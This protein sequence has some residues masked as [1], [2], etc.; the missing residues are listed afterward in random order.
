MDRLWKGVVMLTA[1]CFIFVSAK[2][3]AETI[4]S[5]VDVPEEFSWYGESGATREPVYDDQKNG[6]WWIPDNIPAGQENTQWGNRGYVFVGTKTPA[7]EPLPAPEPEIRERVVERIVEKPVEKIVY[8]DR[9]VE[10]PVEKIVY[11]DK[12]VEKPV[13]KIVYRDRVQTES[14]FLNL[15]DVFFNWDSSQLTPLAQQTLKENA[16]VL[17]ANPNVKVLLVGSASPE[18]DSAY[19]QALS[20]RRIIAVKNYLVN[21]E[22]IADAKLLTEAKGELPTESEA[23]WPFVRKVGFAVVK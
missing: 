5:E 3:I 4:P 15:K 17:R 8:R 14:E 11:R 18:G 2:G 23:T 22:K 20:E 1:L 10:K 16:A 12:I 19:N 7:P 9:I 13:E 21:N 6:L